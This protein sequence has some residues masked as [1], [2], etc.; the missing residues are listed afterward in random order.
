MIKLNS[1]G[2]NGN[3]FAEFPVSAAG[4]KALKQVDF[5]NNPIDKKL[6]MQSLDAIKWRGLFSLYNLQLTKEEYESIQV[7]L[8]LIDVYY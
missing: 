2:L 4:L 8:K 7:K 5:S 1:I 3:Q 6:F